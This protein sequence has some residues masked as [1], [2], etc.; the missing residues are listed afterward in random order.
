MKN[1]WLKRVLSEGTSQR[2]GYGGNQY[3]NLIGMGSWDSKA[4]VLFMKNMGLVACDV[5]LTLYRQDIEINNGMKWEDN[6]KQSIFENCLFP[7]L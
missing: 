6:H 4:N 1:R 5:S 3:G 7:Y 2:V